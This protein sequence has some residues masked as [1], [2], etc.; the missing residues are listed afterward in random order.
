MLSDASRLLLS[1]HLGIET[2]PYMY[3]ATAVCEIYN[4]KLYNNKS[5]NFLPL[6]KY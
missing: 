3:V 2:D 5:F 4:N 1:L 6:D